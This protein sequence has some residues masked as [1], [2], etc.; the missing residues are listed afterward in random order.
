MVEPFVEGRAGVGEAPAPWQPSGTLGGGSQ[1]V[2]HQLFVLE[3]GAD[4]RGDLLEAGSLEVVETTYVA[5]VTTPF[6]VL[7]TVVLGRQAQ[8]LVD[9]IGGPEGAAAGGPAPSG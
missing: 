1:P 3:V 5:P 6:A 7:G 8:A 9:E 2:D 4:E